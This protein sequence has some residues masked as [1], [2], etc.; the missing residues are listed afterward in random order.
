MPKF[1]IHIT[2]TTRYSRVVEAGDIDQALNDAETWLH[3]TVD[4]TA[5]LLLEHRKIEV[6][7]VER[8]FADG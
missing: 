3:E 6:D 1:R 7:S 4:P 5:D 8:R 2:E